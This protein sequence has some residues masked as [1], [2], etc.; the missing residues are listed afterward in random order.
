MSPIQEAGKIHVK[1]DEIN[2]MQDFLVEQI[3]KL[4]KNLETFLK[5]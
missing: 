4:N 5:L 3:M 2:A 1:Q